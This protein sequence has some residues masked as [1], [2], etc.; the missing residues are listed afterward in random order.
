MLK[1]NV[2]FY[3]KKPLKTFGVIKKSF[4]FCSPKRG[5]AGGTAEAVFDEA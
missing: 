1:L 3:S 5:S 4:Y 2:Y